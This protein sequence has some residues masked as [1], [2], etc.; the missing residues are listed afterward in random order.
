MRTRKTTD[1]FVSCCTATWLTSHGNS[2]LLDNRWHFLLSDTTPSNPLSS[3]TNLA[4]QAFDKIEVQQSA[5]DNT[6]YAL[7]VEYDSG[8]ALR[9]AM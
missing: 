6:E 8:R 7:V 1:R 4:S 3:C 9:I 5:I 2:R